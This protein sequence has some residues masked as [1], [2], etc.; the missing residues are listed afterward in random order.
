M[1]RDITATVGGRGR[2]SAWHGWGVAHDD[3]QRIAGFLLDNRAGR[4]WLAGQIFP[5]DLLA[6]TARQAVGEKLSILAEGTAT[7]TELKGRVFAGGAAF[8]GAAQGAIDLANR[9]AVAVKL[10]ALLT[11]PELVMARADAGGRKLGCHD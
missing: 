6:G 2:F 11:R 4:Y 1:K 8:K 9:R 10:R 7:R 5:R 3:G